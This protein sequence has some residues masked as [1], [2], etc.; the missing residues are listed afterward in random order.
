MSMIPEKGAWIMV[1]EY[2][3]EDVVLGRRRIGR[4]DFV[5][6]WTGEKWVPA[7]TMDDVNL[8]IEVVLLGSDLHV[9]RFVVRCR[10]GLEKRLYYNVCSRQR[11]N[12]EI[13]NSEVGE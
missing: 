1:G 5:E 7:R 9:V 2:A 13:M 11:E 12:A 8:N 6:A 10:L 3:L 4:G